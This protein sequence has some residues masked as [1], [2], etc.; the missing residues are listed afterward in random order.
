M[1]FIIDTGGVTRARKTKKGAAIWATKFFLA[2]ERLDSSTQNGA[3][4]AAM[5]L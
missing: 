5:W 3:L 1:T 2:L 4:V